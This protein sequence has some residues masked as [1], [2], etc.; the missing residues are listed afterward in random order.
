MQKEKIMVDMDDTMV[1]GGFLYLINKFLGTDYKEE[2][3]KDYYMQ[4]VIPNKEEFFDFFLKQN[5]YD[6]CKKEDNITE[7]LEEL[8]NEYDVYIGTS[9]IFPEIKNQSGIIVPQKFDFLIKNFPYLDPYKFVFLG[10]KSVL[11]C[12]VR[13]DDK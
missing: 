4:D 7:V 8:N 5:M 3:F 9:Y 1:K 2:D 11:N 12:E 13:I 6:H 10:D